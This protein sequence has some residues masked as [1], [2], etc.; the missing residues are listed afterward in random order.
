M[1]A[2]RR[3]GG[4]KIEEKDRQTQE[5]IIKRKSIGSMLPAAMTARKLSFFLLLAAAGAHTTGAETAPVDPGR[6]PRLVRLLLL[7]EEQA[8]LKELRDDE[9]RRA[10]QQIF[11]ARRDPAP[12]TATNE[13]ESS[14]RA[15]WTRADQLFAY[16]NQKGSETGCGQVLALLGPPEEVQGLETRTRFDNLQYLREGGRRAE[17]W[18]YRDR[19]S[20]AFRFTNAELRVAFDAECRFAEGGILAADLQRA[21]GALVSRPELGYAR[22]G[23]GRLVAPVS[24][25]ASAAGAIDLLSAPRSDFPLAAEA[26]LVLRAPKGE[27]LVAGLAR[28]AT[29][30]SSERVSLAVRADDASG[31]PSATA[32]RES[33]LARLADGSAVASWSLPLKPGR[34]QVTVAAQ[35]ADAGKGGSATL[36]VEVPDYGGAAL[37]A[38]PIVAYPDEPAVA[39]GDARDPWAAM[40]LGPRRIRPRFGNAFQPSD[41]LMLVATIHGARVDPA[42]GKAALRSR[43][44]ILK[45]G[46]PVARGAEDVF[47]T[48]DA[49]ASVGPISLAGYAPGAYVVTLDVTDGVAGQTLRREAPLEIRDGHYPALATLGRGMLLPALGRTHEGDEALRQVFTL[50]DKGVPHHM[51]RLARGAIAEGAKP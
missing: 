51:A 13:L 27:A 22:G 1:V 17:T 47:A 10:F 28:W 20:R 34:Y 18:V 38:S 4:A 30:P 36:D 29:A 26:K 45:E 14:I 39:G 42:T 11:W 43:F 7:P 33:G 37:A 32:V 23:D 50:P 49:V 9:D 31:N 16:P 44:T 2:R 40:Q 6:F 24:R 15:V 3:R 35:L 5:K 12:G 41:G 25:A 19:P 21:A 48:P 8:L 46:K